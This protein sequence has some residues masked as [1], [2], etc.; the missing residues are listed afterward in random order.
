MK[1]HWLTQENIDTDKAPW[2]LGMNRD[3][4]LLAVKTM[5][6]FL[7]VFLL[8]TINLLALSVSLQ[9]NRG[10]N[11]QTGSAL[12]AFMF[13]PV[14]LIMNYYFVRVLS[15][16]DSCEFSTQNPFPYFGP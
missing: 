16:G 2:I 14:Y 5:F 9:C 10:T 7:G 6:L 15:K 12:F 11:K 13:G 4:F 3:Y 8:L 1:T